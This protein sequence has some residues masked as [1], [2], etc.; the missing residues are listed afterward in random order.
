MSNNT[1]KEYAQDDF[2]EALMLFSRAIDK[3]DGLGPGRRCPRRRAGRLSRRA[4]ADIADINGTTNIQGIT[5]NIRAVVGAN[6]SI[7][8]HN[9]F[10][11]GSTTHQHERMLF[12]DVPLSTSTQTSGSNS[13]D[14]ST[15]TGTSSINL[16]PP[17]HT[18]S[19]TGHSFL[20][21]MSSY[22]T[23]NLQNEVTSTPTPQGSILVNVNFGNNA[24]AANAAAAAAAAAAEIRTG[25]TGRLNGDQRRAP[26]RRRRARGGQMR[27]LAYVEPGTAPRRRCVSPNHNLRMVLDDIAREC[28]ASISP[29][30]SPPSDAKDKTNSTSSS[31]QLS[32]RDDQITLVKMMSNLYHKSQKS[33]R[34]ELEGQS[35]ATTVG[36]THDSS[37]ELEGSFSDHSSNRE[38]DCMSSLSSGMDSYASPFAG[39]NRFSQDTDGWITLA[40]LI[41]YDLDR[42]NEG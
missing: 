25:F 3:M 38:C 1:N 40:A 7:E 6:D 29:A 13:D 22:A 37:I 39:D 19:P 4:N 41:E 8:T 15:R 12:V 42:A 27:D 23:D 21:R 24:E 16:L 35:T 14:T 11:S 26:R 31:Q 33:L 20:R 34:T 32:D 5:D 2:D 9:G 10:A 36:T 18:S 17:S 28:C 30:S